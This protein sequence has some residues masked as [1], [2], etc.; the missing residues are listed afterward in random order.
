MDLHLF[1]S[2]GASVTLDGNSV[3][4]TP[5]SGSLKLN[6]ITVG[7][8]TVALTLTGYQRY[9]TH[10][11]VSPNTVSEVSTVLIPEG[12]PS[13]KGAI[14]VSSNPAGANIFVDNNFIGISPLT[15]S[16]ISA[17]NHLVTFKMEGYQEYSTSALI[18]A[19]TT[20]SVS[21]SSCRLLL[22]RNLH[23]SPLPYW[24]LLGLSVS[25]SSCGDRNNIFL[26]S[27]SP[28]TDNIHEKSCI[29]RTGEQ[30]IEGNESICVG[31]GYTGKIVQGGTLPTAVMN[32]IEK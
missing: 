9:S 10:T 30:A 24:R 20:S 8:H 17:G 27:L 19:G 22:H 29:F 23:P 7:D 26:W 18:T 3:G 21:V 13:G 32:Y 28:N 16:D 25:S 14:S 2:G 12:T 1:K 5:A 11:S 6:T 4:Q 31:D 15:A